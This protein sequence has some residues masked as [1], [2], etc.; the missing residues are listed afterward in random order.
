MF[1]ELAQTCPLPLGRLAIYP[2]ASCRDAWEALDE[3]WK[4]GALELGRSYL[5]YV[6]PQ[7]SATDYL[8]YFFTGNRV[9]F[10]EKY[11]ARRH[12]LDALVMSE[13]VADTGE[14]LNDIINGIFCIC[15]ES[16]W[17][18]PL[19]TLIS[20]TRPRFP[21]RTPGNLWLTFSP[22]RLAAY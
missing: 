7:L 1:Y 2:P 16:G 17:Q 18:L 22:A 12:A 15:E 3:D 20:V 19:T 6:Y 21:C 14:F 5:N 13:C 11:F 8:D 10:E 9:R 4:C